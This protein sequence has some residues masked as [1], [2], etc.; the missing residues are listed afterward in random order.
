MAE[1]IDTPKILNPGVSI[2]FKKCLGVFSWHDA[3]AINYTHCPV[4]IVKISCVN[5]L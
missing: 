3:S 4:L 5:I 1:P 2:H